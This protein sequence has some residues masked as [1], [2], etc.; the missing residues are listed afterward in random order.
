MSDRPTE[1]AESKFK[2][3]RME[4]IQAGPNSPNDLAHLHRVHMSNAMLLMAEGLTQM[5]IG[6]R[7][8]YVLL[9]QMQRGQ[10]LGVKR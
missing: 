6:L 7:A 5:A 9:E 4:A 8:T 2:Q 1:L 3:A 10:G